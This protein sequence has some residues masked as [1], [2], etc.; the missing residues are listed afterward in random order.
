MKLQQSTSSST[1]SEI[2]DE[3]LIWLIDVYDKNGAVLPLIGIKY[4][5]HNDECKCQR[6]EQNR[7]NKWPYTESLAAN[8]LYLSG[9]K[10]DEINII[11]VK[12]F[13]DCLFSDFIK[14][15]NEFFI[16]VTDLCNSN[17]EYGLY[18]LNLFRNRS[19]NKKIYHGLT[20]AIIHNYYVKKQ[21]SNYSVNYKIRKYSILQK[22]SSNSFYF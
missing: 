21:T 14:N 12:K 17:N 20:P 10:I 16:Y 9:F 3:Y 4:C 5:T 8:L 18:I 2:T 7:R 22:Q 15:M 6:C 13:E 19:F 1:A 11:Q